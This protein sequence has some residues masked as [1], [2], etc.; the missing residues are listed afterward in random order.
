MTDHQTQKLRSIVQTMSPISLEEMSSIRL[1]KRMDQ[2]FV[3]DANTLIC[4]LALLHEDYFCQEV[5]GLRITS[6]RTVYWDELTEHLLYHT[7]ETGRLPRMKVMA[8][9]Y[10]ESKLS[11]LE[12]KKKNNHGKT[13][14]K[15]IEVPSIQ[16]V[17]EEG[18]GEEFLNEQT[19]LSF[20]NLAPAV[21]N[22][23]QRITLVNRAKT[24]RLTIDF[25]LHFDNFETQRR[26]ALENVAVIELKR[27]GRVASPVLD[28][29]RLLRIKPSGFSKYCIGSALTNDALR[30]NIIKEKIHTIQRIAM[31]GAEDNPTI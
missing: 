28:H 20:A 9:T 22:R 18:V 30:Q 3:T 12:I 2:K 6:Y 27:D 14:K 5:K 17:A 23:F 7:H 1:M 15:R 24:E 16:A 11:F 4:L 25:N 21:G 8:R 10:V 26:A 13:R 31:R 29:L 19:G